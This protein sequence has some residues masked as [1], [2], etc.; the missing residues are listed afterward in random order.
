MTYD[1]TLAGDLINTRFGAAEGFFSNGA[2][3]PGVLRHSGRAFFG[4][5]Y[6]FDGA[7]RGN[8]IGLASWV[9]TEDE[10]NNLFAAADPAITLSGDI[11]ASTTT[12]TLSGVTGLVTSN[13]YI[14]IGGEIIS[15][16][17]LSGNTLTG[18]TR[19]ALGT[20]AASHTSG[21][22]VL[23]NIGPPGS[24]IQYAQTQARVYADSL[25]GLA[26]S[27]AAMPSSGEGIGVAG[28]GRLDSSSSATNVWGGYFEGVRGA[29]T[30]GDG[31]VWGIEIGVMKFDGV[32]DSSERGGTPYNQG[33][34]GQTLGLMIQCGGGN[35]NAQ[36]AD[37]P[38]VFARSSGGAAFY[39]GIVFESGSL[40]SPS[41]RAEAIMLPEDYD[42]SWYGAGDSSRVFN[43][44]S[45]ISDASANAE[46]IA[47]NDGLVYRTLAG[48]GLLTV[49]RVGSAANRLKISAA[50]TGSPV[51]LEAEG[52][53][54]NIDLYAVTK[55]TGRLRVS[56][57]IGAASSAEAFS[58]THILQVKDGTGAIF[59]IP[60]MT[61][62]W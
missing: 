59:Y 6:G 27:G 52:A 44:G 2:N 61:A 15:Y 54:T 36:N 24:R 57:A 1:I 28:F 14:R 35:T 25:T 39:R 49:A 20:T 18:A 5:G 8:N 33:W 17:G 42:I 47:T 22:A 11:N 4:P 7:T 16:V 37:N 48:D 34:N 23:R 55:G 12:I 43:I 32:P 30:E 3:P 53:D 41:G 38:L 13:G 60:A 31:S 29:G 9:H 19:A 45:T 26:I 21:A 51:R 46:L 50:V 40:E 10:G 58:A 62:A 56:Y